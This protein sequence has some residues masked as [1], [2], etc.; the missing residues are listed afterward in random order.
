MAKK[1]RDLQKKMS[2]ERQR[3]NEAA[4]QR[5]LLEMNLQELRQNLAQLSQ[6]D[7]AEA[8]KVTQPY[9]SKLERQG[10]MP[11]SRL[12]QFMSA[13]GGT[14]EIRARIGDKEVLVT[15]FDELSKLSALGV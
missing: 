3:K 4:A 1:Y 15:Q 13:L 6:G 12:Y 11:L 9:I 14:L 2:P 8:L 5:I 7:V 10:D